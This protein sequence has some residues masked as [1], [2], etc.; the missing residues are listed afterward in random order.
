MNDPAILVSVIGL[1][2][3]ASSCVAS[4]VTLVTNRGNHGEDSAEWRGR[5]D[6]KLDLLIG[7]KN[8]VDTVK[9]ACRKNEKNIAV[10]DAST[11]SA[12]HRIDELAGELH[13]QK[14]A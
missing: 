8:D 2:V 11:K 12:H 14:G 5:I 13:G 10:V 9:D 7:I 6:G 4:I 3:A 1:V